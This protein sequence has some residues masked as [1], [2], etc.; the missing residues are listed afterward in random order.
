MTN[1]AWLQPTLER[2]SD[3]LKMPDAHNCYGTAKVIPAVALLAIDFLSQHMAAEDPAPRVVPTLE[4]GLHFEWSGRVSFCA[5][6]F[7]PEGKIAAVYGQEYC[8]DPD[9]VAALVEKALNSFQAEA[10]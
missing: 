10:A 7:Y 4:G 1:Y 5:A 8:Q 9:E 2:I 3:L 6:D